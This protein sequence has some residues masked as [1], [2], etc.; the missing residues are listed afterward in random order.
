MDKLS[1]VSTWVEWKQSFPDEVLELDKS[2]RT[3][4]LTHNKLV[5]EE[6]SKLMN[7]QR[8]VSG[9]R[10]SPMEYNISDTSTAAE[11]TA[12]Q[13]L[14]IVIFYEVSM[15]LTIVVV[16]AQGEPQPLAFDK[17]GLLNPPT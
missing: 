12:N 6:I 8:L 14:T 15:P 5:D 9:G 13:F 16:V 4:D 3:L 17:H 10:K 11:D 1:R 7:M 2:I